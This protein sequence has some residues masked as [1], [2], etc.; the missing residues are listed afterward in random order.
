VHFAISTAYS[1]VAYFEDYISTEEYIDRRY[2]FTRPSGFD[3]THPRSMNGEELPALSTG[4]Y[5]VKV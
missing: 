4:S 3:L 5:N 2:N 1:V